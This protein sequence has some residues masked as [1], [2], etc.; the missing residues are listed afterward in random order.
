MNLPSTGIYKLLA[1]PEAEPVI[2]A[3]LRAHLRLTENDEVKDLDAKL[4]AARMFFERETNRALVTQRWRLT[5][6][7]FPCSSL[8]PIVLAKSPLQSVIS[9]KYYDEDGELQTLRDTEASPPVEGD[10]IITDGKEL[11]EIYLEPEETWPVTQVR[12]GAVII[13]CDFGWKTEEE[14]GEDE[15]DSVLVPEDL[16]LGILYLAAHYFENRE[17]VNI[18]NIV[19]ELGFTLQDIIDKYKVHLF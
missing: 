11:D 16:K 10:F 14:Q 5:L 19:T 17:P 13:E 8:D 12:P 18:G 3:E 15:D 6:D 4:K 1:S 7:S 2:G 9:I